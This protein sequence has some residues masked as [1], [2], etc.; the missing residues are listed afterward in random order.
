LAYFDTLTVPPSE[1]IPIAEE[2]NLILAI[3]DWIL[4]NACRQA[5]SWHDEGLAVGRIAQG[6]LLGKALAACDAHEFLRR[7]AEL[8]DASRSQRLKAI[9]GLTMVAGALGN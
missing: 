8:G 6:F 7:V 1:F 9:L 4:R 5:K 2:T 3:G